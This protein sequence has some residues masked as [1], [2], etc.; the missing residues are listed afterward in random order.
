MRETVAALFEAAGLAVRADAMASFLSRIGTD[1]RQIRA[2]V[3]KLRSYVGERKQVTVQDVQTMV[4]PMRE[5]PGWDLAD[6]FGRRDLPGALTVLRQLLFQRVVP[7]A[8]ISGL[9]GRVRDMLVMREC[10]DR[11]WVQVTGKAPWFKAEWSSSP[12]CE[13]TL[14]A[15]PNDPRRLNPF[16]A[17][18]VAAQAR[19]FTLGELVRVQREVVR[20]HERLVSSSVDD[21]IEME[22]LLVKALG[23]LERAA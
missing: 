20:T 3:E 6:A 18:I 15:M 4:T 5:I 8:M 1:T 11:R 10:I 22:L 23:K 2:E 7:M 17:G 21:A 12:E 14:S 16:R 13:A 19:N 9:E